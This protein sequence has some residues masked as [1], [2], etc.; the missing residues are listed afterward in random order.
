MRATHDPRGS[1]P[2]SWWDAPNTPGATGWLALSRQHELLAGAARAHQAAG[3]PRTPWRA[4]AA[5]LLHSL[6]RRLEAGV[7]QPVPAP[8]RLGRSR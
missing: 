2:P 1:T 3:Q 7:P 8:R 5:A 4:G 6:A